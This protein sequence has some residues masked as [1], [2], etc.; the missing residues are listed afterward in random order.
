MDNINDVLTKFNEL[1]NERKEVIEKIDKF[2]KQRRDLLNENEM[3]EL[4]DNYDEVQQKLESIEQE[5]KISKAEYD[6][7]FNEQLKYSSMK[8]KILEDIFKVNK[9]IVDL[10]KK[11]KLKDELYAKISEMDSSTNA[12]P[13][14]KEEKQELEAKLEELK[15]KKQDYFTS[16]PKNSLEIGEAKT[17]IEIEERLKSGN[18][19]EEEK[20][21]F[22]KFIEDCL[23]KTGIKTPEELFAKAKE[24]VN[25][26]EKAKPTNN[27]LDL[28][29]D[30]VK[31]AA[32][33]EKTEPSELD[34]DE[35]EY[36]RA[37]VGLEKDKEITKED[38]INAQ[39]ALTQDMS[40]KKGKSKV[41][42]FG[43]ATK[44]LAEKAKAKFKGKGSGKVIA[45]VVLAGVAITAI[46]TGG[47]TL[48]AGG[49]SSLSALGTGAIGL[50]AYQDFQKGKKL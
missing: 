27:Y 21:E 6:R 11:I 23:N 30:S 26:P 50:K 8:V 29:Q 38:M 5:L 45:A 35:K 34:N 40:K 39:T 48:L 7:I 17:L 22:K 33:L 19:T 28:S 44:D 18:V 2:N 10:E 32:F 9:E 43:E 31:S 4:N 25:E 36:V 16:V 1:E 20:A 37:K 41:A 15:N 46:A 47:A 14:I 13:A 12:L 24:M 42:K 49:I 3:A